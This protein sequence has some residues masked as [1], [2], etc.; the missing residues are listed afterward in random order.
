MLHVQ[1]RERALCP[2]AS[3]Q[4]PAVACEQV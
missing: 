1:R 4:L 2:L 3:H